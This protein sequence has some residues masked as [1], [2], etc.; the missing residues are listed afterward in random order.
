MKRQTVNFEKYKDQD[1]RQPKKTRTEQ[2]SLTQ[3]RIADADVSYFL[4]HKELGLLKLELQLVF[5]TPKK[6]EALLSYSNYKVFKWAVEQEELELVSYLIDNTTHRSKL[7]TVCHN[8]YEVMKRFIDSCIEQIVA[9]TYQVGRTGAML[10]VLVSPNVKLL[11]QI[12]EDTIDERTS[13]V[14]VASILRSHVRAVISELEKESGECGDNKTEDDISECTNNQQSISP[15]ESDTE[16]FYQN[17]TNEG[18][19]IGTSRSQ[20]SSSVPGTEL[21]ELLVSGLLNLID[22]AP[23][24]LK[25]YVLQ[26]SPIQ[27]LLS[28]LFEQHSTIETRFSECVQGMF[29]SST[30]S[31]REDE[32]T[33]NI[34][35]KAT[36]DIVNATLIDIPMATPHTPQADVIGI[37]SIY[38]SQNVV[39]LCHISHKG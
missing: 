38:M 18:V 28:S 6:M 1:T 33:P 23:K 13:D 10:K 29:N 37:S 25:D 24:W 15:K 31:E 9:G 4:D 22:V 12:V 7:L 35:D 34:E 39:P 2:L 36:V 26:S 17:E 21:A 5:N 8:N 11:T 19:E 27:N 32:N 30:H 20:D 3:K 16:S 14:K